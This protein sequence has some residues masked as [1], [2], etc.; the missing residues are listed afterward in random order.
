M[1]NNHR[2]VSVCIQVY[3]HELSFVI[4]TY[5]YVYKKKVAPVENAGAPMSAA[6]SP[7]CEDRIANEGY[8]TFKV[9]A[10]SFEKL[11]DTHYR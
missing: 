1:V 4:D 9:F 5:R 6:S 10:G 3:L 11:N 7:R 8:L 2:E